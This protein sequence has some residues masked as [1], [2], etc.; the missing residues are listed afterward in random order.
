MVELRYASGLRLR[1]IGVRLGRREETVRK[2]LYL[3]RQT[4]RDCVQ[5]RV[6]A[7]ERA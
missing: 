2:A 3:T 6:R 5:R 1:E 7:E 4:L